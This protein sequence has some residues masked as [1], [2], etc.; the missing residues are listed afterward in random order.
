MYINDFLDLD[1]VRTHYDHL[2]WMLDWEIIS[3]VLHKCFF[4]KCFFE[5]I[6]KTTH[7]CK[8]NTIT[9]SKMQKTHQN[10]GH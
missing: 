4:K 2:L 7:I 3:V 9:F 6:E 8:A 10:H 5:N 1:K